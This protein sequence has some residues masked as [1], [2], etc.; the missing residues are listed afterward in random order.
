MPTEEVDLSQLSS[1][2]QNALQTFIAITGG[3][4]SAAIQLL[5]RSE[6]N[7]QVIMLTPLRSTMTKARMECLII[8]DRLRSPNFSMV[9]ARTLSQKHKLP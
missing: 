4:E 6:W 8:H 5:Q 9:M 3:E 1:S 2:Q 7:T